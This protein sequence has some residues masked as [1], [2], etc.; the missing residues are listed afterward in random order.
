[1]KK[2]TNFTDSIHDSKLDKFYLILFSQ[3][4]FQFYWNFNLKINLNN[5]KIKVELKPHHCFFYLI[6]FT[7][8]SL[9]SRPD[10]YTQWKCEK[11]PLI[12][13][14]KSAFEYEK[15][16]FLFPSHFLWFI[17]ILS[18]CQ[19]N[20]VSDSYLFSPFWLLK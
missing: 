15:K 16:F 8:K 3:F 11:S 7:S 13:S 6:N 18:Q 4:F 9:F 20:I 17:Y 12:H 10:A 1:M 5:L 19:L 2:M 14:I